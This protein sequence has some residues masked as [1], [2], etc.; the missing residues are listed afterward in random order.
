[1]PQWLRNLVMLVTLGAWLVV[2]GFTLK[3]GKLP[4][5]A[6]LGIPAAVVIALAPPISIRRRGGDEPGSDED[7]A[8]S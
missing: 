3:Q 4:D 2:V 8:A 7:G 6:V 1:M 5:A